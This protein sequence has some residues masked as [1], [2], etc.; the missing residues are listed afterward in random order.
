MN[1]WRTKIIAKLIL[2]GFPFG[3]NWWSSIGLFRHGA[4]NDYS[5]AWK[6]LNVHAKFLSK[7]ESWIGLELGPGEWFTTCTS[8][9]SIGSKGLDLGRYW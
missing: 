6:V 3:Y 5:Y 1:L 2:S 8:C 4:M 7:K 9:T